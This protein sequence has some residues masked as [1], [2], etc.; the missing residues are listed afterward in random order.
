MKLNPIAFEL[1]YGGR[2]YFTDNIGVY[3]EIGIARS[4]LQLGLCAKF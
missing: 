3:G 1:T 2:Y 4:Y